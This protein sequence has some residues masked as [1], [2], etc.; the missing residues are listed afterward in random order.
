MT[1]NLTQFV[2]SLGG[3]GSA[4]EFMPPDTA[5][6]YIFDATSYSLNEC[7]CQ[8]GQQVHSW[9]VPPGIS[10]ASF[11][12]WGAGGPGAPLGQCG[13][14]VPSG[15]GAYA[16]KTVSVTPGECYNMVV[17][18]MW[19]CCSDVA[20]TAVWKTTP[21]QNDGGN[22]AGYGKTYVTGTGLTNF[23][24]EGGFSGNFACC[25]LT[26][27][28]TTLF[29]SSEAYYGQSPNDSA[30]GP[31]RA[32]YYGADGGLRGRKGYINPNG[33][34]PDQLCNF[35]AWVP[36]PNCSVYGKCGGHAY[37]AACCNQHNPHDNWRHF[38]ENVEQGYCGN[39][40]SMQNNWDYAGAGSGI[41]T[42]CGGNCYCG[43]RAGAGKARVIFR[44]ELTWLRI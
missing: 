19:C 25:D 20:N 2:K 26:D 18:H 34:G 11:H 29:D 35:R 30:G 43:G 3:G 7:S 44:Q 21:V 23:C 27:F 38:A 13:V 37:H 24:A 17:G 1:K 28:A 10:Q 32:W 31:Y 41:G 14:G 40:Q 33:L 16:F 9:C 12:I 6:S 22:W 39:T 15:S 36:L 4:S 42:T 8:Y 5:D